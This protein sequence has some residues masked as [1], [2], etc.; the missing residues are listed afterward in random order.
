MAVSTLS[1]AARIAGQ[2]ANKTPNTAV[3]RTHPA[4]ASGVTP[5]TS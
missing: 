5:S 2:I 4:K 1:L 3:A